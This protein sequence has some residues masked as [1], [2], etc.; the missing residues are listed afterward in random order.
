MCVYDDAK[1]KKVKVKKV[2]RFELT[3]PSVRRFTLFPLFLPYW[4]LP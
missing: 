4:F 1:N 2:K 3:V